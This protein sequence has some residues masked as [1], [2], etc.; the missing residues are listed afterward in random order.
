MD[1][2]NNNASSNI[3]LHRILDDLIEKYE[4]NDYVYGR[5]CNYM[6]KLLPPA[7]E[8][9]VI[10]YKQRE[11]RKKQLTSNKDEFTS[12]FLQK[13]NYFFSIILKNNNYS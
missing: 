9:S 13:N 3:N 7:L 4:N 10:I 5:L 6:E 8:N 12:R 11:D 1:T 2:I